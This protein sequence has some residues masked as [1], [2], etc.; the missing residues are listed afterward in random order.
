MPAQKVVYKFI[1]KYVQLDK[2]TY[3][4]HNSKSKY[5]NIREANTHAPT[6]LTHN[7]WGATC[8]ME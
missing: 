4:M 6:L 3:R 1:F 7:H 2:I 8:V 5:F